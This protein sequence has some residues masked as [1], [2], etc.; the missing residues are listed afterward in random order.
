M[1]NKINHP[2]DNEIDSRIQNAELKVNNLEDQ[3]WDLRKQIS[4]QDAQIK[5]LMRFLDRNRI[6]EESLKDESMPSQ[7]NEY[8]NTEHVL[9]RNKL[10][11][12]DQGEKPHNSLTYEDLE[13]IQNLIETTQKLNLISLSAYSDKYDIRV[14]I[15]CDYADVLSNTVTVG[16]STSWRD[17]Y[18]IVNGEL[19]YER[20]MR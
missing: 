8:H 20:S 6:Q 3:F 17:Y 9:R 14:Y 2:N 10:S 12:A 19:V 5:L 11:N 7:E 1:E 18:N 15:R 4:L 13:L 16:G